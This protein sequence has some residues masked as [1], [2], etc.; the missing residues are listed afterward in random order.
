VTGQFANA[1]RT[2]TIRGGASGLALTSFYALDG[3]I[4]C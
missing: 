2:T 4:S 1:R 3:T